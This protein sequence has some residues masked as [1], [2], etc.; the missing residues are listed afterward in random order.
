MMSRT[1]GCQRYSMLLSPTLNKFDYVGGGDSC[2]ITDSFSWRCKTACM[3]AQ[4]QVHSVH[5]VR[6]TDRIFEDLSSILGPIHPGKTSRWLAMRDTLEGFELQA[7]Y[8]DKLWMVSISQWILEPFFLR[9]DSAFN[10]S[11][12]NVPAA[13]RQII[14]NAGI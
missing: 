1:I 14:S 7:A 13:T 4:F 5:G 2:I 12:Q 3:T 9:V 6:S 11:P 10:F 8:S